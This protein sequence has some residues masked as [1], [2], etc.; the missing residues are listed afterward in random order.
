MKTSVFV[1]SLIVTVFVANLQAQAPARRLPACKQV[2]QQVRL[3]LNTGTA[4][5]LPPPATIDPIW[6]LAPSTPVYTTQPFNAPTLWLP[7]STVARWI[8]PSNT[9]TP[10]TYPLG[11]QAYQTLFTTPVDPYL[12]SSIQVTGAYAADDSTTLKLNG[13]AIANCPPGTSSSTW[14]FHG[15]KP[16]PATT[17]WT[18]FNR[19]PGYLNTLRFEVANTSPNSPGGLIVRAEVVAVCSKCTTPIPPVEP[20]CGGNPS[21]C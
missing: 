5:P 13:I 18:N 20:P 15:W 3:T 7:N 11:T 1:S 4:G 6:R 2:G 12:Y 9:G 17:S 16:I 19:A 14:C 21:T 8:Q 10:G